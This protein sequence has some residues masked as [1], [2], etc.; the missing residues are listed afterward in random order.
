MITLGPLPLLFNLQRGMIVLLSY[1][2]V[3]VKYIT[4]IAYD[5]MQTIVFQK[6]MAS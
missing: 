4:F 3:A 6:I 1:Y 5:V 2:D